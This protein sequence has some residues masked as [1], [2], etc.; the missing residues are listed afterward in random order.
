MPTDKIIFDRSAFHG[1]QFE[2]LKNSELDHLSNSRRISIYH[3]VIFLEETISMYLLESKKDELKKQLPF[4]FKICNGRWLRPKQEVWDKELV[5]ELCEKECVFIPESERAKQ[6][7]TICEM[8]FEDKVDPVLITKI[9]NEK[10]IAYQKAQNIRQT[11]IKMRN[12]I[13]KRLK[14]ENKTRR[15]IQQTA[16]EFIANEMAFLGTEM[17][18]KH[19]DTKKDKDQIIKKWSANMDRFPYFSFFVRGLAFAMYYA[20]SEPNK[21]VEMNVTTDIENLSYLQGTDIIVSNDL[22][23]MKAAFDQLWNEKSKR[24][25]TTEQFVSY[26]E[27]LGKN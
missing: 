27:H 14:K 18:L 13:S 17:I 19:L 16:G 10:K 8:V 12:D 1:E 7:K 4:I 22:R 5:E 3:P 24:F 9:L 15:D 2:M 6:E 11:C 23:F 26:L 20:M 25:M 21:E